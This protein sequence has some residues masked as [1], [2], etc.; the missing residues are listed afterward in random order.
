[1]E[2]NGTYAAMSHESRIHW[3]LRQLSWTTSY[4]ALSITNYTIG[5]DVKSMASSVELIYTAYRW[6]IFF[7]YF[8][9]DPVVTC[10]VRLLCKL[11]AAKPSLPDDG[12]VAVNYLSMSWCRHINWIILERWRIDWVRIITRTIY[13]TSVDSLASSIQDRLA[14]EL[15]KYRRSYIEESIWVMFDL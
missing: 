10:D 6:A 1:M 12:R 4:S 11:L 5:G 8:Q 14:W 7:Q 13:T 2:S 15:R 9:D 3:I